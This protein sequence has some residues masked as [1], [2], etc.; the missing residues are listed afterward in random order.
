[1][2]AGKRAAEAA[3]QL[4][5]LA[6]QV[7]ALIATDVTTRLAH[8]QS[9]ARHLAR[10]QDALEKELR[11]RTGGGEGQPPVSGESAR[12][13][14]D[15]AGKERGRSDEARTLADWLQNRHPE[16]E[17]ANPQL[18]RDWR[19]AAEANSPSVAA[20]QMRRAADAL[21][22]GQIERAARDVKGS[23]RSLHEL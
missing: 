19:R 22:A 4:E 15:Q 14:G 9:M 10:E 13:R 5:R 12:A 18:G 6:K 7:A 1:V 23:G 11:D 3:E 16:A 17:V 20:D 8:G 2:E 21:G